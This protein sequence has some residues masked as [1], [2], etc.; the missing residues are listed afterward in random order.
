MKLAELEQFLKDCIKAEISFPRNKMTV[1]V[2]D[3]YEQVPDC[4]HNIFPLEF[5]VRIDQEFIS[6]LI[7]PEL[8]K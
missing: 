1:I 5:N 4:N 7:Q 2:E 8:Q 3:F 6:V